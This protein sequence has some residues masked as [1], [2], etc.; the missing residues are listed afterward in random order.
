MPLLAI[1]IMELAGRDSGDIERKLYI[2]DAFLAPLS[3]LE[4]LQMMLSLTSPFLLVYSKCDKFASDMSRSTSGWYSIMMVPTVIL[5]SY[6][7]P[8]AA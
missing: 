4:A 2:G 7:A 8:S 3:F 6:S 5:G 1:D